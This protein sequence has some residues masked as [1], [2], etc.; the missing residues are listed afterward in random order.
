MLVKKKININKMK[1][2][3]RAEC[4]ST[5]VSFRAFLTP[6]Q[7]YGIKK[8]KRVLSKLHYFKT[9]FINIPKKSCA[10]R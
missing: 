2:L 10:C 5:N 8:I 1:V 7:N 6:T 3:A 4:L 9:G